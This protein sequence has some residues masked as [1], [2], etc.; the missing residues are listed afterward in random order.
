MTILSPSLAD[1]RRSRAASVWAWA[2]LSG[3]VSA[4]LAVAWLMGMSSLKDPPPPGMQQASGYIASMARVHFTK[5]YTYIHL[6]I[7]SEGQSGKL[8]QTWYYRAELEQF[9]PGLQSLRVGDFVSAS[10]VSAVHGNATRKVFELRRGDESL[11]GFDQIRAF[12][13]DQALTAGVV[14]LFLGA[15]SAV[16]GLIYRLLMIRAENTAPGQF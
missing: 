1:K 5:D 3:L 11:L 8:A 15:L 9:A 13:E 6:G 4:A 12:R 2:A 10:T 16:L 14:A 7:H